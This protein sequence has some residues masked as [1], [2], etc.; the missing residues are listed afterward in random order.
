[1][2]RKVHCSACGYAVLTFADADGILHY[3]THDRQGEL[4]ATSGCSNSLSPAA[5]EELIDYDRDRL[6]FVLTG[7]QSR[8]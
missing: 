1:M 3:V 6:R 4:A 2:R 8:W 5:T 7:Q